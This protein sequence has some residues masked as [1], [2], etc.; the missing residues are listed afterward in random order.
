MIKIRLQRF[1]SKCLALAI[2]LLALPLG[3]MPQSGHAQTPALALQCAGTSTTTY[4]PGLTNTTQSTTVTASDNLSVCTQLSLPPV[5]LSGTAQAQFVRN[6][7]CVILLSGGPGSSVIKWST[8]DSSTFNW[9]ST[10]TEVNGNFVV[11]QTGTI[12]SGR[13]SGQSAASTR[14]LTPI[15]SG[16]LDIATACNSPTGIIG[17]NG[18]YTLTITAL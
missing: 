7:S 5:I 2:A 8:G 16:E 17:N 18:T 14:V 12:T 13:Y 9:T 15:L 1:V 3:L 10:I 4:S 6:E 11:V